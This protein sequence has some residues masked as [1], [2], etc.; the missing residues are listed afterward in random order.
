MATMQPS[1]QALLQLTARDAFLIL[2]YCINS[3]PV[4]V[5]RVMGDSLPAGALAGFDAAVSDA[6]AAILWVGA[7]HKA[8]LAALRAI[9]P[10]FGGMGMPVHD[11]LAAQK[12]MLLS[13]ALTSDYVTTVQPG[14]E[15][16][17]KILFGEVGGFRLRF[18]E[19]TKVAMDSGVPSLIRKVGKEEI[20]RL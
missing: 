4:F 9:S 10:N 5:S 18:S 6:L 3:Q 2:Y 16:L 14:W 7:E 1:Q 12:N 13:I 8:Q 11:G 17:P 20:L 15:Q 19:E